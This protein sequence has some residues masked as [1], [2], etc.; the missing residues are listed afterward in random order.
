MGLLLNG[1]MYV[2]KE[3]ADRADNE[4][5]DDEAV[6]A[7]LMALHAALEAGSITEEAFEERELE[8]V[9]RLQEIEERKAPRRPPRRKLRVTRR[10][11]SAAK[12]ETVAFVDAEAASMDAETA[13]MDARTA[14]VDVASPGVDAASMPVATDHMSVDAAAKR[15][16]DIPPSNRTERDR[17]HA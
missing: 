14:P 11:A 6:K 10:R 17:V 4:L 1:L 13:S 9:Q 12:P 7:D 15:T 3:I 2:F 5:N 8:L 16:S